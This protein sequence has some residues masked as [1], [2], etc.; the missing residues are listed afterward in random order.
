MSGMIRKNFY[1]ST[2]QVARLDQESVKLGI[3]SSEI[4]RRALDEFLKPQPETK[5]ELQ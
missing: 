4:L 1:L 5:L 3:S 2:V